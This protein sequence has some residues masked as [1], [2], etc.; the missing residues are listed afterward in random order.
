[1]SGIRSRTA[2]GTVF[3]S[4]LLATTAL[5]T[6]RPL[7]AAEAIE[8]VVV[9][10]EKRTEDVQ[11]VPLSIQVIGNQKIEELH[12]QSFNDYAQFLPS[13]AFAANA[14]GGGLN[15]PGFAN[16]YMRGVAS[17][18]DGNHS[19]S[20]PSVGMYLDEQPITTIGGSLDIHMYDIARV[21]ALAGPQGTLYGASSEAGT[22]RIITN[23]P[24]TSGFSAAYDVEANDVDHG[25]VGAAAEGYVNI[26]I[27]SNA[28]IR[29]VAW[30]EHDAGFIDNVAGTDL[31]GG[32]VN[33]VRTYPIGPISVSN[34][35]F[36]KKDENYTDIYGGRAAL[37]INLDN[38]W[39]IT[40]T[41]MGQETRDHGSYAYNPAVGDLQ[42]VKFAPEFSNDSWYQAA[43][44]VQGRVGNLDLTYATAYM[45]RHVKSQLDYSDYAFFY[46][47]YYDSYASPPGYLGQFYT[48][49]NGNLI[50]PQ[51]IIKGYDHFT[52]QSHEL[53]VVSSDEGPFR[54]TAGLF[55]QRQNHDIIQQYVVPNFADNLSIPGWA[56]TLWL[57]NQVRTDQD[58]A[59]FAEVSYKI[60]PA[61]TLTLGGRVFES[62]NS[63]KGFFGFSEN[64]DNLVGFSSGMPNC[65]EGPVV[66]NTPCTDLFKTTSE[67]GFTHKLNVNWQVNGDDLLYFTWSTG[68][69]PGGVNRN[70]SAASDAYRPDYLTNYE[71]GWKTSWLDNTLRWNGAVY[72]EDWKDFQFSFLGPNSLTI[73][74]NA[75]QARIIGMESD[76]VWR[77]SDDFTLTAG[78]SYNDAELTQ[79]YCKDPTNCP[80]TEQAP[81]GQQLPITPRFKGNA[82]G[83]YTWNMMGL[84]AHLQ[85]AVVYN[86]S[87]WPDL[88]T[89]DRNVEGQM[90]A[91]TNVDFAAGVAKN[92]WWA[93]LSLE[94]AFDQRDDLYNYSECT[95][96][97]CGP[98]RYVVTNRPRTIAIRVGQKF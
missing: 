74:A 65:F 19:A 67:K 59:A 24:D 34:A 36:R 70:A 11:H 66:K 68:F 25:G 2:T 54:F 50:S 88:R 40:P 72:W 91:Y 31:A 21:E 23:K 4:A 89:F 93:E 80:A 33:G 10:A 95:A 46:D 7:H 63:L 16:V 43:L 3:L 76:V 9:T 97:T 83:R 53:R 20:Q 60:F 51:Q 22:I 41:F 92:N 71:A 82:T 56:N 17:G 58:E 27:A 30:D 18:G 6:V 32:I 94:N 90:K 8:T 84:N 12:I 85:A 86:G 49:N 38:N 5:T 61:L 48:D 26:P 42:V 13:V 73:I 81:K 62:D 47:T 87:A 44:T 39:T 14:Q 77:V 52:K 15:G 96:G 37:Q 35:P 79:P 64:W 45:D 29:I 55:Y 75:G 28:A 98:V 57:T 78:G 1:M 69:R